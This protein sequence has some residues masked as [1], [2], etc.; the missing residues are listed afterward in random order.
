[1]VRLLR[2]RAGLTQR[3]THGEIARITNRY[4]IDLGLNDRYWAR[5]YGT[6]LFIYNTRTRRAIIELG[7]VCDP[8]SGD[9][10]GSKPLVRCREVVLLGGIYNR[11]VP[12]NLW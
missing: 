7:C 3:D 4:L 5:E 9:L 2:D 1:M 6:R 8:V 11:N 10:D 12:R